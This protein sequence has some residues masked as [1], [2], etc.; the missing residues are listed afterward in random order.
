MSPE[1]LQSLPMSKM[2]FARASRRQRGLLDRIFRLPGE[3]QYCLD[4]LIDGKSVHSAINGTRNSYDLVCHLGWGDC[5][6]R[7]ELIDELLLRRPAALPD[8]RRRLFGCHMCDDLWCGTVSVVIENRESWVIWRDFAYQTPGDESPSLEEF[9]DLGPFKFD[10]SDYEA[11]LLH[12][13]SLDSLC[14]I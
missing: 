7:D 6:Y 8:G 11:V 1:D 10:A 13:P 14:D 4:I 9:R 5:D 12:I 3:R 2:A